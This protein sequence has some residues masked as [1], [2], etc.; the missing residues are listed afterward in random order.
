MVMG[1]YSTEAP[2]SLARQAQGLNS[3]DY[4]EQAEGPS[5]IDGQEVGLESSGNGGRQRIYTVLVKVARRGFRRF[6]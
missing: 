6:W 2:D 3:S 1:V 4:G 5:R